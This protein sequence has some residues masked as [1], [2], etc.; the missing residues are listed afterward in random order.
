MPLLTHIPHERFAQHYAVHGN[1][2]KAVAD[3]GLKDTREARHLLYHPKVS[4]RIEEIVGEAFREAR[5]SATRTLTELGRIAYFDIREL[6]D[7]EGHLRPVYELDDDAAA[8]VARIDVEIDGHGRG[9]DRVLTITKKIRTA[10]KMAALS[11]LARHFKIVGEDDDGVNNLVNALA[12]RLKQARAR[13]SLDNVSDAVIHEAEAALPAVG[14]R[15][16]YGVSEDPSNANE[17]TPPRWVMP[18]RDPQALHS[19][20]PVPEREVFVPRTKPPAPTSPD[21]EMW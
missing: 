7:A 21:D 3:L 6:Y 5:V 16:E 4:A 14:A 8:A 17:V 11:V 1:M 10:D 15:L 18:Q 2:R 13:T 19:R 20:L 12:D 9:E